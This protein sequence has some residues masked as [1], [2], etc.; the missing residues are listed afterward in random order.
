MNYEWVQLF[1]STQTIGSHNYD[2]ST[3]MALYIPEGIDPYES[4]S[5]IF[6]LNNFGEVG[7]Y[8]D[9]T[10]SGAYENID[11]ESQTITGAVHVLR[12]S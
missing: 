8:V 9:I 4:P 5:I 1:S 10:F 2:S 7:T 11:G 12:D 6:N 3:G